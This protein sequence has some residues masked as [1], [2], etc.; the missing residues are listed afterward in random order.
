MKT[1]LLCLLL[2]GQWFKVIKEKQFFLGR[3]KNRTKAI[4]VVNKNRWN[5]KINQSD[6]E[7]RV[8][9]CGWESK[10]ITECSKTQ[11]GRSYC[12]RSFNPLYLL[13]VISS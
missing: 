1:L 9:E 12:K 5:N 6:V 4:I 11:S 3:L 10:P 7:A 13:K 8:S 2:Q